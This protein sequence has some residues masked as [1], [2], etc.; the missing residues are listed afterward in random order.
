MGRK[1]GK[2]K[3]V[4]RGWEAGSKERYAA[5]LKLSSNLCCTNLC[6][7][8]FERYNCTAGYGYPGR[9]SYWKKQ[10]LETEKKNSIQIYRLV[11]K[12]NPT[13]VSIRVPLAAITHS[14]PLN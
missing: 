14:V 2:E 4:R 6:F 13:L 1:G 3:E 9:N 5:L 11:Q 10:L 7:Q 8:D 12:T